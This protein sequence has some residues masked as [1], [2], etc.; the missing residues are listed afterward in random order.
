VYA[1][2]IAGRDA[3]TFGEAKNSWLTGTAAWNYVAISQWILGIQPT[4]DG[5]KIAPVIPNDW[6]GFTATRHWRGVDYHIHVQRQGPGNAAR[7]AVNGEPITG[8]IVPPSPEGQTEVNV[9][10]I[11]GQA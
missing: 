9:D 10:V 8:N 5:L 7:I 11:L 4:L 3:A 6:P 2:M 1:Q